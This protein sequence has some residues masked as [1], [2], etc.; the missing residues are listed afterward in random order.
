MRGRKP[1]PGA[2][3][4]EFGAYSVY[5]LTAPGSERPRY[6]GMTSDPRTRWIM[7]VHH[8]R[9]SGGS[10]L[11]PLA[12]W[13]LDL[14]GKGKRPVMTVLECM[15]PDKA[16]ALLREEQ[17]IA[18]LR[19]E[20]EDLLNL[21]LGQRTCGYDRWVT[22]NQPRLAAALRRRQATEREALIREA[23]SSAEHRARA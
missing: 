19:A 15:G 23:A 1:S 3:V 9:S 17:T 11:K 5:V 14:Y 22:E 6:V 8:A 13:I 18:A 4:G 12:V 10:L 7:H 16:Y 20:G 2:P 21:T